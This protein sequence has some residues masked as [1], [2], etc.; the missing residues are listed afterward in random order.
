MTIKIMDLQG[1]EIKTLKFA[2]KQLTLE[3]DKMSPESILY[4]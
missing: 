4:K 1:K 2:G 3:C